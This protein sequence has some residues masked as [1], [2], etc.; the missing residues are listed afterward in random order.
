MRSDRAFVHTLL[1]TLLLLL[2]SVRARAAET[3]TVPPCG[4]TPGVTAA[5]YSGL[6]QV[7]ISG[8]LD[9][10]PGNPLQDAFYGVDPSDHSVAVG[11]CQG[12]L[13]YNRA[14]EGSCLCSYEC[15]G[16]SHPIESLLVDPL[17]A[18]EPS[19][20]YSVVLDL[21]AA[22]PDALHFGMADCGCGDNSGEYTV[23]IDTAPTTTTTTEPPTTTSTEPTT[24]TTTTSTT[25]TT[26]GC[27]APRDNGSLFVARAGSGRVTEY[28]TSGPAELRSFSATTPTGVAVGPNGYLYIADQTGMQ[29]DNAEILRVE[30]AT[31]QVTTFATTGIA[32]IFGLTFGPNGNLFA[33]STRVGAGAK[34]VEYDASS[35]AVVGTFVAGPVQSPAPGGLAFGPNGNLYVGE[36]GAVHEYDGGTGA[37]VR[38]FASGAPLAAPNGL[39]FAPSGDLLVADSLGGLL[40]LDA[41]TGALVRTIDTGSFS[42]VALD[43]AGT[44]YASHLDT[45]E[46]RRYAW[47]SGVPQG[48][49]LAVSG[50]PHGIAFADVRAQLNA[51][52]D[53]LSSCVAATPSD[54]DGDGEADPSDRCPDTPIA[55]D[56]DSDGCSLAQFCALFDATTR[57]G[58]KSCK[59][60]DWRNDEPLMKRRD[61]DCVIEK[62]A[63]RPA[64]DRCVARGQ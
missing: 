31:G 33:S 60:A 59:R 10:T 56:V 21:G 47:P 22:P 46:I 30:L 28:A 5:S 57:D 29:A 55:V 24:T 37:F 32:G 48:A 19:H 36:A 58:A 43:P 18:F 62:G 23:T 15:P 14:S 50:Y 9:N 52:Q 63:T 16:T 44:L 13:R 51:C 40:E 54:A 26:V 3:I 61:A 27:G 42:S 7:T 11:P 41:V 25:T 49:L 1:A 35:G 38:V 17:P 12:C 39:L 6:V 20:V 45:G 8:L 53:A 34:V 2:W 4:S 64:D